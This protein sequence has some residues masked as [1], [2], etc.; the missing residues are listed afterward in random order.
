[1]TSEVTHLTGQ[2]NEA[3]SDRLAYKKQNLMKNKVPEGFIGV[4]CYIILS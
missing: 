3:S 1:M 2:S 4:G